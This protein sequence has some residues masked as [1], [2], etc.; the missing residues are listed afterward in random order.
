[1]NIVI[2]NLNKSD[3]LCI[4]WSNISNVGRKMKNFDKYSILGFKFNNK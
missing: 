1:M 2:K 3:L 4:G